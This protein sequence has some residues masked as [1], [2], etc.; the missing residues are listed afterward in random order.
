MMIVYG[1][2]YYLS[3]DMPNGVPFPHQLFV[4]RSAAEAG[5][6]YPQ[7]CRHPAA[8]LGAEPRIWVVGNRHQLNPYRAVTRAQAAVLR[9]R[10][11]LSLVKHVR[12]LTVFLLVRK[13]G[14]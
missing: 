14:A 13:T 2:P 12:G 7:R 5:T 8:C 10:Y 3:R 4:A 9:P 1:L 6:L 11:Q